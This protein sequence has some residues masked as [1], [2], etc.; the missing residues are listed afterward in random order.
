MDEEQANGNT[1][2]G[3][4]LASCPIPITNYKEVTL[5]H[6]SGGKLT[7]QLIQKMI[8][9]QFS[10]ELLD[11]LH[12]GAIFSIQGARLAFS[13]DS[14]VINP[15]F[16]PG[17]DIGKLAVHGTVNDIAMCGARP[18][19]LSVSFILEEG[20]PMEDLW[21]IVLSMQ[22][23]ATEAGVQLVT[24]DTKVVD[25][26]KGDQIFINTS[27]I[28]VIDEGVQIDQQR[29][30]AGDKIIINGPIALHGMAILSVREGLE[31]ETEIISDT[32]PLNGLVA[33]MLATGKD[34]RLLRDPTRGGVASTVAELAD[35]TGLGIKL[36][37]ARIPISPEARAACEILG[38]DPLH[39]ANEGKL[40]AI[41]APDACDDILAAMHTH[42]YG[43]QATVIGEVVT[44]HPKM[45]IM[46][47]LV[48]GNRV[49][50][51]L[52][53]GQLPR[54]C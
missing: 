54:I 23:A 52:S 7:H 18:L 28:G 16:F 33:D 4:L 8:R 41:V 35:A 3:A 39:V 20:M 40:I 43:R 19:Y 50:D 48:G 32:A 46:K 30:Q 11:P 36:E 37:E 34:I 27:G 10:N 44:D 2:I 38:L 29:I 15:I 5:G 22:E 1:D 9:P 14:Y 47:T 45:V 24:G 25:R 26:G 17:G 49:V 12:D 53:G 51:M 21:R 6:G 42:P 31:F 13:T